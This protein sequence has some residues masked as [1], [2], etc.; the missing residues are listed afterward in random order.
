MAKDDINFDELDKAVSSVLQQRPAAGPD[1]KAEPE[2]AKSTEVVEKTTELPE[3]PQVTTPSA[4]EAK[5]VMVVEDEKPAEEAKV[6][7]K[8]EEKAL[9]QDSLAAPRRRGQFMDMV[10]SRGDSLSASAKPAYASRK[11]NV[12]Q[13][14]SPAVVEVDE[15]PEEV[16]DVAKG[17][18]IAESE[19]V[20]VKEDTNSIN[21]PAEQEEVADEL[22]EKAVDEDLAPTSP[23]IAGTEVEKRPLGAFTDNNE[24]EADET[25]ELPVEKPVPQEFVPEL[26]SVEAD[27]QTFGEGDAEVELTKQEVNAGLQSI[28]QQ[29]KVQQEEADTETHPV[30]DTDQYHQPLMPP[31]KQRKGGKV[32]LYLFVIVFMLGLGALAGYL[33]WV[34]KII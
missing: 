24:I 8:S 33:V 7:E 29:Y 34:L 2:E 27:R 10:R 5:V 25:K 22:P 31:P 17:T 6:T 11:A 15:K 14:L 18:Q 23:F 13:P 21:I 26:I 30:F 28:S 12:L 19:P 32:L 16:E 4:D 20:A 1:K 9:V 3:V